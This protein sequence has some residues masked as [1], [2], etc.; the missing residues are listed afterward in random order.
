MKIAIVGQGIMGSLL[1]YQLQQNPN[2]RL[3][4]CDATLPEDAPNLP[5]A[6][7]WQAGGMV[8][9]FAEGATGDTAIARLGGD[10]PKRWL[11]IAQ[12]LPHAAS[13][14]QRGSLVI[15]HRRDQGLL[16]DFRHKLRFTLADNPSAARNLD[17]TALRALEAD[18]EAFQDGI[19]LPTEGH[20]DPQV[21]LPALRTELA[22]NPRV[23]SLWGR[24]VTPK[25][26]YLLADNEELGPF[27]WVVDCRGLGARS[28]LTELRGIRGEALEVYCPE[29]SISRPIRLL[30]PRYRIY[31][32]PR[33][34][35]R[36]YIG[37]T[38]LET[39]SLGTISVESSL[40]LLSALYS[41]APS[42]KHAQLGRSYVGL[43]PALPSGLPTIR[44]HQGLLAINGLSRHGFLLAP[45]LAA[46][47]RHILV[48]AAADFS[49]QLFEEIICADIC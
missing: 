28:D 2:L 31:V 26:H 23:T 18:L 40:E 5:S 22:K 35:S 29:F 36:F 39:E 9:P 4:I 1:A 48:G 45:L 10:A 15:C 27:D 41:L 25:A 7:S 12:D 17:A 49:Q 3:T 6:T 13:Y 21:L 19:A 16:A 46:M 38:S 8:A 14:Q 43:R 30:H 47:A 37:A 42:L 32:I 20:L 33:S 24:Q 44:H 11:R 34:K